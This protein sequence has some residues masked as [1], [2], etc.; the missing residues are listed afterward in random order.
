MGIKQLLGIAAVSLAA[1]SAQAQVVGP[2]GPGNLGY[3]DNLFAILI[4]YHPQ[5]FAGFADNYLFSVHGPSGL[6]ST[7]IPL[8]VVDATIPAADAATI[9]AIVLFDGAGGVLGSDFDGSDGYTINALLPTAGTYD[10]VVVGLGG[11]G[12]GAYVSL[13]GTASM[14]PEPDSLVM[15]LLGLSLL[16]W[17]GRR[18]QLASA[19]T[20]AA[21]AIG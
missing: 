12:A 4:G 14:V 9:S 18:H 11:S 6:F 1:S 8:S 13:T 15:T 7:I 2:Y 5:D 16:G 3:L 17:Y 21:A 19:R 20:A 10:L